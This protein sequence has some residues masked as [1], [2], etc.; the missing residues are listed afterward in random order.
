MKTK[1]YIFLIVLALSIMAGIYQ[2]EAKGTPAGTRITNRATVEFKEGTNVND[3]IST[4]VMAIY[5]MTPVTGATDSST[6]A[7]GEASFIYYITNNGN[8]SLDFTITLSNFVP[9]SSSSVTNWIAWL[10]L[11][12]SRTIQGTSAPPV[13]YTNTMN[14]GDVTCYTLFVQTDGSS[15]PLDW[16]RIPM[17][18]SSTAANALSGISYTGDNGIV[19]G[20]VGGTNVDI[21]YPRIT[22]DAPLIIVRKAMSILN[23]PIYLTMVGINTNIP[24]PDAVITY[25]NYYT[26]AGSAS[27]KNLVIIDTIPYHT[28]FIAGSE[29]IVSGIHPGLGGVTVTYPTSK[30]IRF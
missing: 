17:V 22:I 20:G 26:N 5:G 23:M 3:M 10:S 7:G 18:L 25:T 1:I 12:P 2:A 27:A 29:D 16:G 15:Q 28:D 4:N 30:R 24:V 6:F 19:Y 8:T 9:A 21:L 13:S 14:I 11:D